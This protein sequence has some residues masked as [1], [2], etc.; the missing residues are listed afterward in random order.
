MKTAAVERE[1][2][3]G[4]GRTLPG[5]RIATLFV[6]LN[7]FA[8]LLTVGA[9]LIGFFVPAF[10][11]MLHYHIPMGLL[12]AV[13]GLFGLVA[14]MF[15]LV[16]TGASIKEAVA[17]RGISK[18][19]FLRT[20]PLKKTLFPF[21]MATITLLIAMTVLGGAVHVGKVDWKV[22]LFFALATVIAYY[23]TIR[24]MKD[25]FQKDRELIADVLE[26]IDA[27]SPPP[28]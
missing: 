25:V 24:K 8:A 22:H 26:A 2:R 7:T 12:A 1:R 13:I 5:T 28:Q 15:Y 18:E 3:A 14:A 16:V 4:E 20:A 9:A 23:Y 10:P 19:Y 11:D 21:C 6:Y 17:G 27:S